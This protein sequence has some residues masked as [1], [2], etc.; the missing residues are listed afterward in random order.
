[1]TSCRRCGRTLNYPRSI[2]HGCGSFCYYKKGCPP[3]KYA[4]R[5]PMFQIENHTHYLKSITRG[6]LV[7]VAIGV[8]CAVVHMACIAAAFIKKHELIF[9][10][11][12]MLYSVIKSSHE[13]DGYAIPLIREFGSISFN[14]LTDSERDSVSQ[15]VGI[16]LSNYAGKY[17]IPESLS[18]PIAEETTRKVMSSGSSL[19]FNWGS[20]VLM[21]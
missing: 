20:S 8:S 21:R 3:V 11:A 4:N 13:N 10:G 7:G 17:G 14:E 2:K 15:F 1:M 6:V 18:K 12:S 9:K 5:S 16:E 19:A